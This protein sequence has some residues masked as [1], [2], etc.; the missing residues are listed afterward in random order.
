MFLIAENIRESNLS[1]INIAITMKVSILEKGNA[2]KL[3]EW[4]K[5]IKD[6]EYADIL[7]RVLKESRKN[8][9]LR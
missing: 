5:A 2:A 3:L 4:F 9:T 6:E 8:L 1:E 7:E